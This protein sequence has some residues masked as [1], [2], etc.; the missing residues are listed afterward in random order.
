VPPELAAER[1]LDNGGWATIVT[2]RTAIEARVLVIDRVLPLRVAGRAVHQIGLPYHWALGLV[3][4]PVEAS[5]PAR[6]M[7][8]LGS[9]LEISAAT[10]AERAPGLVSEPCRTGRP[11]AALRASRVLGG[12]GALAAVAGRR[13]RAVSVLSGA[14]LTGAVCARYGVF[15]AGVGSAED[16]RYGR[17]PATGAP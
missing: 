13:S 17:G 8:P 10:R 7:A 3:A 14:L 4:V 9:A 6:R 15:A 2:S 5:G 1:G 11:G 16:P 12:A